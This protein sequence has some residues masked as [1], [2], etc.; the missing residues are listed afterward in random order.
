MLG[1]GLALALTGCGF[2]PV[3]GPGSTGETLDGTVFVQ[4]AGGA[5]GFMLTQSLQ[6]RLGPP[7]D[8]PRYRLTTS[9]STSSE[10][11]AV[12][13][14]QS[15]NRFNLIGVVNYTLTDIATGAIRTQGRVDGFNSYSATGISVATRAAERSGYERLMVILSDKIMSNLL[16]LPRPTP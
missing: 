2:S 11:V 6:N 13:T 14:A 5:L 3:Y 7:G 12:T 16:A 9:I 1:G 8:T 15:T 4:Q 10:R